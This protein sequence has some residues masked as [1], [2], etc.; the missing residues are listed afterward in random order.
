M[1]PLDLPARLG[2]SV[3]L[4]HCVPCRLVWFDPL[5][6]V[7]L[8]GLG[9]VRLLRELQREAPA[10]ADAGPPGPAAR[11]SPGC[12][13]CSA[14]LAEVHNRTR[15][16]RF[17]ALECPRGHGHLHAQVGLLAERGLVRTL[18]P[19]ERQALRQEH[20]R[21]NCLSCGAALDGSRDDC[22][23][24]ASPLVVV[25]LPRLAHAL[26]M[27]G[28]DDTSPRPEGAPLAWACRG[29]GAPLDPVTQTACP[30][31]GHAVAAPS[32]LDI[33]PLLDAAEDALQPPPPRPARPKPPRPPRGWRDTH[34]Q[35]LRGLWNDE[36]GLAAGGWGKAAAAAAAVAALLAWL[37]N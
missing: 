5:E 9:W 22:A 26:T 18:L 3:H 13:V 17:V 12:P 10:P 15:F 32:L 20:R 31:C 16:G 29:C 27:R 7:K 33:T 24:C 34:V 28:L 19:P 35:R 23:H 21:W 2:Q 30:G 14:P 36:R 4:D 6:S 37:S 8:G 1:A 11:A 25:D